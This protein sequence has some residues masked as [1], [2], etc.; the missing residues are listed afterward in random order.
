VRARLEQWLVDYLAG[1]GFVH[2]Y[3]RFV[4]GPADRIHDD[5]GK[6][7]RWTDVVLNTR[8]GHIYLGA[9]VILGHGCMLLTG[10]HEYA[11]GKLK[12]RK[13][14]VPDSGWDIRVGEG[15]WIAS[16]AIIIGGVTVGE[17]AIVA[18]GAVVTSDVAANAIVG[19][20][21]ARV[22]GSTAGEAQ[23]PSIP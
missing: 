15:A 7:D 2:R 10:R 21:P 20:N 1:L 5:R 23:T 6:G 19:G 9:D 14:Q 12:P 17:H 3:R 11:D 13:Q 16:G 22:I 8:S 18:A 4:H